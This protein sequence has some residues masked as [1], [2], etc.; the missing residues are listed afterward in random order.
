M[1]TLH[2]GRNVLD[3]QIL[4]NDERRCGNVD[5]LAIEGGPGERAFVVAILSGPGYWPQRAG[6]LGRIAAWIGRYGRTRIPWDEVE[7]IDS[8]VHLKRRA[9]DYGLGRADDRLRP[10]LQRIPG[11]NR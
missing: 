5:D 3:H 9:H 6:L 2:V 4:D 10:F 8:G 1:S 7:T 11:A